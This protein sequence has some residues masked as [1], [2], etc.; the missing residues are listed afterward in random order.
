MDPTDHD[1]RQF[2]HMTQLFALT[3]L[4]YYIILYSSLTLNEKEHFWRVAEDHSDSLV[5]QAADDHLK[6]AMTLPRENTNW[7]R[8][9]GHQW[10]T[11]IFS[12][13]S[14]GIAH[15]AHKVVDKPFS[16]LEK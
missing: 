7:M 10:L 2:L 5:C 1:H 15:W 14:A 4:G 11:H 3:W 13:I 16:G 12:S 9:G 8:D 6:I